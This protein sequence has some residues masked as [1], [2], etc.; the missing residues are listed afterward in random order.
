MVRD[1]LEAP[2]MRDTADG[3]VRCA[4]ARLPNTCGCSLGFSN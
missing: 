3:A 4:A 1:L 2:T